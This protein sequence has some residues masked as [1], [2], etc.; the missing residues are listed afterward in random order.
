VSAAFTL[1]SVAVPL[2]VMVT[3]KFTAPPGPTGL[4]LVRALAICIS[5]M[6]LSIASNTALMSE[7][8]PAK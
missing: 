5:Q 7:G 3:L 4:V 2:L 6:S 8:P 1:S